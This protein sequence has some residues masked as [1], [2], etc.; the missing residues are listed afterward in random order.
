[1]LLVDDDAYFRSLLAAQLQ[2]LNITQVWQAEDGARALSRLTLSGRPDLV[3]CDLQMPTMSGVEFLR[4]LWL[5][6]FSGEVLLVSG[7][8]DHMLHASGELASAY[9]LHLLGA[10]QKPLSTEQLKSLLSRQQV[11]PDSPKGP[12]GST[13]SMGA[14]RDE[15]AQALDNEAIE[16]RYQPRLSL[17]DG[18]LSG[19]SA[20]LHWPGP[21]DRDMAHAALL[22]LAEESGLNKRLTHYLLN[23][24]LQPLSPLLHKRP[25]LAL[26]LSLLADDLADA[27][28]PGELTAQAQRA[29]IA[30]AKLILEIPGLPSRVP[31]EK[32]L[33]I[34]GELSLCGAQLGLAGIGIGYAELE[35]LMQL[36]LR[37]FTF[38][39][40]FVRGA[41]Q[42]RHAPAILASQAALIRQLGLYAVADGIETEAD[43]K[44]AQGVGCQQAQGDFAAPPMPVDA[45]EYWAAWFS[46]EQLLHGSEAGQTGGE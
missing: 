3:I 6:G 10:T 21:G 15:L 5:Q 35:R 42:R 44:L 27:N 33:H 29:D 46:P 4:Q 12:A 9:G 34:A 22:A 31:M 8:G 18:R 1:M 37:A 41:H 32:I 11:W 16:V 36:P 23:Q 45:L 38:D 25:E 7:E 43:W 30:T 14:S 20:Q 39:A 2:S 17:R 28:L 26:S 24:G 40:G 19:L 13:R